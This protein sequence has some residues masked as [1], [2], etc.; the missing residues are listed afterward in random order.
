MNH[1]KLIGGAGLLGALAIVGAIAFSNPDGE[2][3]ETVVPTAAKPEQ[4]TLVHAQR[5]RVQ[6]PFQHVWRADKPMVNTGWL[7]VLAGDAE[8]LQPRQ[9]KEPVLYVGEQTADRM[10]FGASG[11]LVVI[12]PGDFR[13]QDAPIFFGPEALPEELHARDIRA[14]LA[15]AKAAGAKA[16][17]QA[18]IAQATVDGVL[19]F[20]SDYELRLRAIDLVEEH[21][22]QETDL[23]SGW[24]APLVK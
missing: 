16:P 11:K 4:M 1:S 2:S 15:N 22:P 23:I 12:V 9:W 8:K 13:L 21:S 7:L 24:R 3:D 17:N 19:T 6:R 5:F 14:A 20:E 10:N 18:T